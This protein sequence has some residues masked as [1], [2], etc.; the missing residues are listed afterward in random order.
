MIGPGQP[1]SFPTRL[2]AAPDVLYIAVTQRITCLVEVFSLTELTSDH[3]PILK[4]IDWDHYIPALCHRL[5]PASPLD[6]VR[7][8]DEAVV[9]IDKA[10]ISVVDMSYHMQAGLTPDYECIPEKVS[11]GGIYFLKHW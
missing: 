3:D 2:N 1:T 11:P 10:I 8:I 9:G 7:L 5:P 6:T 4:V